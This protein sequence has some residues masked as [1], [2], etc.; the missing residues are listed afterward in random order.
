[1]IWKLAY[2][3][4][5][6]IPQLLAMNPQVTNPNRIYVGQKLVVS[7]EK[8]NTVGMPQVSK[9]IAYL[10]GTY[11]GDFYDSGVQQVGV[12]FT[13]EDNIVKSTSFR[14]LFYGGVD[15]RAEKEDK[16]IIAMTEQYTELLKFLEGKD[17]RAGIE[18]L[19]TPGDIVA[20]KTV[21]TDVV[22][23]ATVRSAKVISAMNDGLNRGLYSEGV[24]SVKYE[25]GTYRGA[26][27]D[28]GVQQ[29]GV[30][31]T[32]ADKKVKAI[33]YRVLA[34][35]GFDYRSEK[36]NAR[37]MA[38]TEQHMELANYLLEKDLR[39]ALDDLYNPGNIVQDK[40]VGTDAVTGATLRSTKVVSAINDGLNRG[41][42]SYPAGAVP[43]PSIQS[44]TLADGTYRGS[45]IDSGA[46][47]VGIQVTIKD[48]I[49]TAISFRTLF[50]GG[51]DYRKEVIDQ[52]VV[53]MTE[54]Y[55]ELIQYL[56]G[57][58]VRSNLVNLYTPGSFV[59]DKTVG[60]DAVS[61][62]T[63]R[64]NKVISAINDAFNRGLY[65]K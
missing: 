7:A 42:Y 12:Q 19:Y 46:Q 13:L 44:K 41:I 45:Y 64:S 65:S 59:A 18:K 11:R 32:L 43:A 23:G 24:P 9:A 63:I 1:M 38:I 5:L 49:V 3:F 53:A 26:Y 30:Q 54:Q 10:N 52:K 28:G 60:T 20:D 48:H 16:K 50:Y 6:T 14:S 33:S 15:Y 40:T 58:D 8:T 29:V 55:N 39:L 31:F 56:V 36:E 61:G 34:H 51:I 35:G 22:T 37:V 25:A 2:R 4:N 27:S 21:G 17:I 62:A 57:K 47:Q